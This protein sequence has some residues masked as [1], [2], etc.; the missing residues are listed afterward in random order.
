MGHTGSEDNVAD[1]SATVTASHQPHLSGWSD[2]GS[3]TMQSPPAQTHLTCASRPPST[4]DHCLLGPSPAGPLGEHTSGCHRPCTAWPS[5][6]SQ[7]C[8]NPVVA[9]ASSP[10]S[11]SPTHYLFEVLC[12]EVG[13]VVGE[14]H[15]P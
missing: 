9:Q 14:Y 15:H 10:C 5:P 12:G 11:A 4:G 7:T 3:H 13:G 2:K 1:F 8:H 6:P